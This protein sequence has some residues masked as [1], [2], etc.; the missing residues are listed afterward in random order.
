M[1]KLTANRWKV[2]IGYQR[3]ALYNKKCNLANGYESYECERKQKEEVAR[4]QCRG[5]IKVK[6]D[7][8][9]VMAEHSHAPLVG[10]A[11]MLKTQS[12]T[13]ERASNI[14]ETPQLTIYGAAAD[15]GELVA[16]MMLCDSH[17][18]TICFVSY[19]CL[20]YFEILFILE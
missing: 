3:H 8:V 11:D 18:T 12:D 19:L 5:R 10:R 20:V 13:K 14:L 15:L 7:E 4:D 6:N 2:K 1:E 9:A 16:N 17:F